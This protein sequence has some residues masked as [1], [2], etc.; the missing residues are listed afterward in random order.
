MG[1][2]ICWEWNWFGNYCVSKT[3]TSANWISI[4]NIIV[5]S[6]QRCPYQFWIPTPFPHTSVLCWYVSLHS[7]VKWRPYL[8]YIWPDCKSYAFDEFPSA[9][10]AFQLRHGRHYELEYPPPPPGW[11]IGRMLSFK[12]NS[13]AE[14][15][16]KLT[17]N[18]HN[19]IYCRLWWPAILCVTLAR[20]IPNS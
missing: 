6:L 2:R 7:A 19:I 3:G 8:V 20:W 1:H 12:F 17:Y 9:F 4:L 10:V 5:T 14:L 18:R 11:A 15:S 13:R 16:E